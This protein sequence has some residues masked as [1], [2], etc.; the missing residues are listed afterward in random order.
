MSGKKSGKLFAFLTIIFI[1]V[2][3]VSL[4][5]Y[6]YNPIG[7]LENGP[8]Y[9]IFLWLLA[10][11]GIAGSLV[12]GF[13]WIRRCKGKSL[14]KKYLLALGVAIIILFPYY[15][16]SSYLQN[17]QYFQINVNGVERQYL[18]YV[19]T[20]YS[21]GQAV[22]LLLALHGGSGNAKQFEDETGFNQIAEREGFIVVYPDGLGTF[23][24]ALHVW[25]SGY[26]KAASDMGTDDVSFIM[27]LVAY[28]KT[29]YSIDT[30]RVYITGHSNG[31]MMTDRIAAEHPEL[32]AAAAPVSSSVGGKA[33]PNSQNYTIPTPSQ[34]ISI[35]RVHG[36]Q[37]DNVLYFGGYSKSGFSVGVRYDDSENVSTSFWVN[38]NGCQSTPT[39]S[40]S[41]NGLISMERFS[42]GKNSTEVVLVTINNENHFW[43]NMN[44]AVKNEQFYGNSLAE[45]IWNLIKVYHNP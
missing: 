8:R 29:T 45:M 22:P 21:A 44:S 14:A 13:L 26:I 30:A 11:F 19:P 37:D 40:N 17:Q 18:M 32:F 24:F 28:L 1:V 35:V 7:A 27:D 39:V 2:G 6:L 4:A 20:A 16:V 10:G 15:I 33:T 41:S 42:G 34:P 12:S 23:K 9:V 3:L 31:A 36:L 5:L 25:N 38:N 43:G